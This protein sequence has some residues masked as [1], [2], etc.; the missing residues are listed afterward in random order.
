MSTPRPTRRSGPVLSILLAVAALAGAA[1]VSKRLMDRQAPSAPPQAAP[2]QRAQAAAVDGPAEDPG[3]FQVTAAIGLVEAERDGRWYAI[4]NGDTL[5]RTDVVRTAAGARAVLQ[6]SAGTEIELRER[7]EIGLDR[8]AS[9]PT[10]DLRR[11]KL[12]AR[13]SGADALAITS[14]ETRTANE[15]PAHFVVL[16]DPQ[17]RV[18]VATFSGSAR[19]AAGGR[20]VVLPAG[21]QSSS[22]GGAAPGDPERIPEEVFLEVV[23]PVG[24][25]R[26]ATDHTEIH[27]RA[28]PSSVVTVNGSAAAVDT[29][30]HFTTAVPLREGKN[31]VAVEVEDLSGRTRQAATTVV[32]HGPPQPALTPETTELWKR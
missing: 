4:K 6:L 10:V 14:H 1:I 19:F 12:L 18:S 17:G 29:D 15:G 5:T 26:H 25:Q 2:V 23:W 31:D 22:E 20:A 30:G 16:S 28:A 27:G 32:R 21:T 9:G 11:G 3:T 8:L 24:E 13:V 7:V